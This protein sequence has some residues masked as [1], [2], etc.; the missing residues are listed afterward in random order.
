MSTSKNFISVLNFQIESEYKTNIFNK[1]Y[2]KF[3]N[4]RKNDI[5]YNVQLFLESYKKNIKIYQYENFILFCDCITEIFLKWSIL[6]T[7]YQ[8]SFDHSDFYN[9]KYNIDNYFYG[10]FKYVKF[11]LYEL[12]YNSIHSKKI[13]II[14]DDSFLF[15]KTNDEIYSFFIDD[16]YNLFVNTIFNNKLNLALYKE[17]PNIETTYFN[18]SYSLLYDKKIYLIN[19]EN[20]S[21]FLREE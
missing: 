4:E 6:F 11:N 7:K 9:G 15:D 5:I 10:F 8:P 18:Y 12:I 14:K 2:N 20:Y 16:I 1:Y 13:G 21:V 3:L 19:Y 17:L